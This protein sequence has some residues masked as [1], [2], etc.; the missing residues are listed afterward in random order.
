MSRTRSNPTWVTPSGTAIHH[1]NAQ[2]AGYRSIHR[3]EA[4]P[5]QARVE[6]E[7][8]KFSELAAGWSI[9]DGTMVGPKGKNIKT[10]R[11]FFNG[12]DTGKYALD[13]RK[14]VALTHKHAALRAA[15]ATAVSNPK[16]YRPVSQIAEEIVLD[17]KSPSRAA[18]PYLQAMHFMTS[19]TDNYGAE[20]HVVDYF[21]SNATAWKGETA[22]RIK[23]ELN[24]MLKAAK[25][26]KKNPSKGQVLARA[27]ALE[28]AFDAD[29]WDADRSAVPFQ[30]EL[31]RARHVEQAY[32]SEHSSPARARILSQ[33]RALESEFDADA[34]DAERSAVPFQ[35]ELKRAR[36]VERMYDAE[37]NVGRG[38]RAHGMES[39]ETRENPTRKGLRVSERPCVIIQNTGT[40]QNPAATVTVAQR[41]A[42]LSRM[43]AKRV[44]GM[45]SGAK[46]IVYG[47]AKPGLFSRNLG[48]AFYLVG[49][50]SKR[51]LDD[52]SEYGLPVTYIPGAEPRQLLHIFDAFSPASRPHTPVLTYDM[53]TDEL[54]DMGTISSFLEHLSG[55]GARAAAKP[56]RSLRNPSEELRGDLKSPLGI[57]IDMIKFVLK[58]GKS[59]ITK[60]YLERRIAAGNESARIQYRQMGFR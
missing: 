20:G 6:A 58:N 15:G 8:E 48:P 55:S 4:L 44:P 3:G 50:L 51:N 18:I 49:G 16:T 29:Q 21:L 46:I 34:Y 26:A 10:Y 28:E 25:A 24:A 17:W 14:A 19:V 39:E 53:Y 30:R 56:K 40:R 60:E 12:A 43:E 42:L 59:S 9:Q 57:D 32:T 5:A 23:A 41:E 27:R 1:T 7:V 35:R 2:W 47:P 13:Y 37:D 22:R 54:K 11:L 38:V 33:A 31:Q 36:S 45:R 52:T